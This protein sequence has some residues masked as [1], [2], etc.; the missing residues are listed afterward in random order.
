MLLGCLQRCPGLARRLVQQAWAHAW[1][2]GTEVANFV[3]AGKP[4]DELVSGLPR[5]RGYIQRFMKM[6]IDLGIYQGS[7]QMIID[8]ETFP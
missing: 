7:M 4:P 1:L 3:L 6:C 8:F 5:S 2:L